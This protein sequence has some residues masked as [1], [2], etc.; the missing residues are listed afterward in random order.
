MQIVLLDT[1][2]TG[3][4]DHA[5]M[6]QLAYKNITTGDELNEYYKPSIPISYGAMAIHHITEEMVAENPVFIGSDDQSQ[7]IKIL[8]NNV[9]VAHNALF[10]I[11]ILNNEEVKVNKYIDTLRVARHVVD[12]EQYSMQ[13]LRYF[14][15]LEVEGQAHDA[16]GDVIV[17]EAL[18]EYLK[19]IVK[20]KYSLSSDNECFK[21]MLKLTN[22]PVIL[23]I[24]KFGKY[25]GKTFGQVKE[26]D[27]GYLDW[28]YK[29]ELL[30][31]NQ[32]Q[33]EDLFYTLQKILLK[34][35]T[36]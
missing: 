27:E 1:E 25:K 23:D 18:F 31:E 32:D 5:R 16:M 12:A 34:K 36:K 8:K 11:K 22:T 20:E 17:L 9:M 13:Y 10:D 35:S 28:L 24:L 7:L 21:K 33:N 4:D 3:L 2:A 15:K 30:K 29:S 14:L 6:I 19:N 26:K